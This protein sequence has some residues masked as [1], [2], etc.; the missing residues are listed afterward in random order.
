MRSILEPRIAGRG[1]DELLFPSP[2]DSARKIGEPYK[3]LDAIAAK[4]DPSIL[5]GVAKRVRQ[6][7]VRLR[8]KMLRHTYCATRLQSWERGFDPVTG[9]EVEVAVTVERV[10]MEMGHGSLEMV[11][12]I[13]H[14]VQEHPQ[15]YPMVEYRSTVPS[16]VGTG[17]ENGVWGTAQNRRKML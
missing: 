11:I 6:P 3:A 7:L 13:Y 8:T 2:R 1:G 12:K 16:E 5:Q 17:T 4:L 9:E 14:H 15:R 10:A